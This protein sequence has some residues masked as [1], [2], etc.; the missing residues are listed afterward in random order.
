MVGFQGDSI[1]CRSQL[2]RRFLNLGWRKRISLA[3]FKD[4]TKDEPKTPRIPDR[5]A[6]RNCHESGTGK[7]LRGQRAD[8]D[9]ANVCKSSFHSHGAFS[10]LG[11]V[12]DA[13]VGI[14]VGVLG[15]R[16]F[17]F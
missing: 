13:L 9:L 6:R 8:G 14:A 17:S 1:C 11:A 4:I 5:P 10:M 12:L 3:R 7:R 2:W 15:K 16:V